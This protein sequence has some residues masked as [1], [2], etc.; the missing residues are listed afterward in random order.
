VSTL[1]VPCDARVGFHRLNVRGLLAL[2]LAAESRHQSPSFGIAR[3]ALAVATYLRP[4][5]YLAHP[6]GGV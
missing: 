3:G 6:L 5:A 4:V 2:L 1:D